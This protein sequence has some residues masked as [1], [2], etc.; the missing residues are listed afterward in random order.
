MKKTARILYTAPEQDATIYWASGFWT[1]DPFLYIET[2]AGERLIYISGFEYERA[3]NEANDG[4]TVLQ[5]G[6]GDTIRG[7]FRKHGIKR[8][9]V[10]NNFPIRL[11]NKLKRSGFK[12][13]IEDFLFPERKIKTSREITE[14]RTVQRAA[15]KALERAIE[16]IRK[17]EIGQSGYVYYERKPLTSE[18]LRG[19]IQRGL[20]DYDCAVPQGIIASSGKDS[21]EPHNIG[22]GR[23]R[24]YTP[25][26]LDVFPRSQISHYW[27][28]LTRTV[29]KGKAPER[30][31]Q[32]YDAVYLAQSF[33]L[34]GIKAGGD[35]LKLNE[36]VRKFMADRGFENNVVGGVEAGF[37]HSLGH[38][39]GLDIHEGPNFSKDPILQEGEVVTV[40]PGLY[41]PNIGGV[42][43]EDV[44]SV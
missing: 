44:V 5:F 3:R 33:A 20:L 13:E 2:P 6:K 4:I 42:R 39:L 43:I 41:Y 32:M 40:E 19:A 15:E 11:Y 35:F 7:I 26:V 22:K 38:R 34:R 14:I 24:A 31:K 25:I 9:S 23:G 36:E 18:I 21:A 12:V 29:V 1:T 27:G 28:D 17:S 16:I 10:S 30:V 8:I 37:I